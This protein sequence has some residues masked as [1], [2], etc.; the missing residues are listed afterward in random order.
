M[1]IL[2][3]HALGQLFEE[4]SQ[5]TAGLKGRTGEMERQRAEL[6]LREKILS[7]RRAAEESHAAILQ[8]VHRLKEELMSFKDWQAESARYVP[9]QFEPGVTVYL[10][11]DAVQSGQPATH[12]CPNCYA[13]RK[14][15]MLQGTEE[16]YQ[17]R[18]GRICLTCDK[19]LFYGP[20]ETYPDIHVRRGGGGSWMGG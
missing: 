9:Q 14:I 2:T 7:A 15:R 8:E 12:Y 10:E 16:T 18:K 1:T 4:L 5:D 11:K 13:E 20:K 6:D 19:K 17:A 3:P